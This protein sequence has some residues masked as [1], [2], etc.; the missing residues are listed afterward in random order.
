MNDDMERGVAL[1]P[2]AVMAYEI[3]RCVSVGRVGFLRHQEHMA[4][5][6]PDGILGTPDA[7]DGLVEVK[8]PRS[9]RHLSYVWEGVIPSEHR[10]QLVHQLW[11]SGASYVDFVSFDPL[12]PERLQLMVCRLGRDEDEIA[13]YEKRALAFLEEVAA[14]YQSLMTMAGPREQWQRAMEAV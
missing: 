12:M 3:H 4:G 10:A 7:I 14:A 11:I 8:A 2:Q 5:A 1:E 13:S 6:S 9:A